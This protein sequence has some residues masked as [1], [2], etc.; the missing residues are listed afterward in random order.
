M[1]LDDREEEIMAGLYVLLIFSVLACIFM[2]CWA[3]RDTI[4]ELRKKKH[5]RIIK[6]K[7]YLPIEME[8]R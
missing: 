8:K 6:E 4:L 1:G 7:G 3:V 2:L 5:D